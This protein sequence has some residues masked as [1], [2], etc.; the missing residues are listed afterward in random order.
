MLFGLLLGGYINLVLV[1]ICWELIFVKFC[2][3][4]FSLYL[5][6]YVLVLKFWFNIYGCDWF[7]LNLGGL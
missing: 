3:L 6:F 5:L 7:Y 1:F 2:W 4:I